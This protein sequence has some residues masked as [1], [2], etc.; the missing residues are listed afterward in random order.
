MSATSRLEVCIHMGNDEV[1]GGLIVVQNGKKPI[2]IYGTKSSAVLDDTPAPDAAV[3][4]IAECLESVIQELLLTGIQRASS[5]KVKNEVV[6][7]HCT[8]SS[9]WFIS[10]T[11]IAGTKEPAP[12]EISET[13]LNDLLSQQE[14]GFKNDLHPS[15]RVFEKSALSYRLN[16]YETHNPIG[17]SCS[18]MEVAYYFSAAEATLLDQIEHSIQK[19]IHPQ[20]IIFHSFSY[21]TYLMV[22]TVPGSPHQCLIVDAGSEITEVGIVKDGV[23]VRTVSV[24]IGTHHFMRAISRALQVNPQVALSFFRLF[25]A[26]KTEDGTTERLKSVI[27]SASLEWQSILHKSLTDLAGELFLPQSIF[28]TTDHELTPYFA[29]LFRDQ[30]LNQFSSENDAFIVT[31]LTN[32]MLNESYLI[33]DAAV[34]DPLIIIEFL[35][36]LPEIK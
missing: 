13:L 24:P 9:P 32:G 6:R 16:G 10:Q 15:L 17:K 35:S 4:K 3:R 8:L 2:L 18:D 31:D 34:I 25:I 19:F 33:S 14:S 23:L 26:G 7:L 12:F 22:R 36:L 20:Q 28:I 27:D 29:K 11:R 5:Y 1:S 30:R 21:L